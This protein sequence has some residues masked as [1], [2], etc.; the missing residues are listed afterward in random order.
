MN[1]FSV[2]CA[3]IEEEEEEEFLLLLNRQRNSPRNMFLQRRSEG[4][5]ETF[6]KRYLIDYE[7][8]FMGYFRVSREIFIKILMAIKDDISDT[9]PRTRKR[10]F[11]ITA[12]ENLF[13]TLRY[14]ATGESFRSLSFQFQ[15][16]H[17]WI[18]R[19]VPTVLQSI[20]LRLLNVALPEPTEEDF[21]RIAEEY[22]FLWNFPNCIY[23]YIVE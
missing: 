9:Q 2:I 14:L 23:R 15:I 7:E 8:K 1:N 12:Q 10:N 4:C 6:I 11:A 19:I 13:L 20:C 18:C 3:L 17:N 16:S 21:K 22:C 5:Y